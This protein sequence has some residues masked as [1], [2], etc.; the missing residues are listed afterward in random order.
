M[1]TTGLVLLLVL[2]GNPAVGAEYRESQ[3]AGHARQQSPLR[4]ID[5]DM[6]RSEYRKAYRKNQRLVVDF[7]EFH[8]KRALKST[9]IPERAIGLAG[10]AAL[11]P[12]RDTRFNLNS[13]KTMAVEF[14]DVMHEDRALLLEFK[15]KW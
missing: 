12:L 6:S 10:S 9:G 4:T 5:L 11:L 7:M 13:S 8:S 3:T 1:R 2:A 15:R 14:Q